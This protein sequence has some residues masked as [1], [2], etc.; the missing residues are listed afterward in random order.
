MDPEDLISIAF[1]NAESLLTDNRRDQSANGHKDADRQE[2]FNKMHRGSYGDQHD[3]VKPDESEDEHSSY[4]EW[5]RVFML[6]AVIFPR[7]SLRE[8]AFKQ[9]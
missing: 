9:R 5:F 3:S 1:C 8:I 2:D 4:I 7:S 6:R